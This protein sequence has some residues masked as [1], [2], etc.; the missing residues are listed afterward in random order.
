MKDIK[1]TPGTWHVDG[2]NLTAVIAKKEGD[3]HYEHVCSCNFGYYSNKS[4]F[5]LNKANARLIAAA[6]ELLEALQKLTEHFAPF[7]ETPFE[8]GLLGDCY[9]AIKKATTEII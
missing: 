9:E 3:R 6:P 2:F 8:H 1:R 4:D 5:E 7:V